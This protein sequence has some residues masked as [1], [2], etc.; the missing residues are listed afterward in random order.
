[1]LLVPKA[2]LEPA[3]SKESLGPQPSVYTNSTTW[4]KSSYGFDYCFVV[5]GAVYSLRAYQLDPQLFVLL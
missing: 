3:R 2:G 4:A 1:M 5:N